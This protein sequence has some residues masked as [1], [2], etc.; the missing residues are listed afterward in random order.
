MFEYTCDNWVVIKM[1]GDDD[2][3]PI[4]DRC[5]S[6]DPY[7]HSAWYVRSAATTVLQGNPTNHG[8]Y[9]DDASLRFHDPSHRIFW[10]R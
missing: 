1:K 7:R 4:G 9:A 8:L 6:F 5:V 2:T 10:D 3:C